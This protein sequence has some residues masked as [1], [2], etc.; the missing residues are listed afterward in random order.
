MGVEGF[1]FAAAGVGV[2]IRVHGLDLCD[3]HFVDEGGWRNAWDSVSYCG[4]E[5]V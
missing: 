3:H 1:V 4:V 5:G 2:V